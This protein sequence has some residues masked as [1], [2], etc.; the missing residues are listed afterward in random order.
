MLIVPV[1]N[2]IGCVAVWITY[3]ELCRLVWTLVMH[4]ERDDVSQV[5]DTA[6]TMVSIV[7]GLAKPC[8]THEF[9]VHYNSHIW[10]LCIG[11]NTNNRKRVC[12]A[13]WIVSQ[14]VLWCHLFCKLQSSQST[15]AWFI[16]SA[17]LFSY[18][19]WLK[20]RAKWQTIIIIKS[21]ENFQPHTPCPS[22]LS[23]SNKVPVQF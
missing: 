14:C 6:P 23:P 8:D 9:L 17:K 3:F 12:S 1:G 10:Y 18:L 13:Y 2:R 4:I 11:I 20:S 16:P 7:P 21:K 22:I 5:V 19:L 15:S